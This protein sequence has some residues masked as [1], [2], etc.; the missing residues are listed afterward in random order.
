MKN[1]DVCQHFGKKKLNT[2]FGIYGNPTEI[3][4]IIKNQFCAKIASLCMGF[5]LG[6]LHGYFLHYDFQPNLNF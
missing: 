4:M 2:A 1:E 5:D 6:K 3:P